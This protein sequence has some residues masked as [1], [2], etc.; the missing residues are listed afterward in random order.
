MLRKVIGALKTVRGFFIDESKDVEEIDIKKWLDNNLEYG[1]Y[2]LTDTKVT[3]TA[4][5][6]QSNGVHIYSAGS[7][8]TEVGGDFI[9]DAEPSILLMIDTGKGLFSNA[10]SQEELID[11]IGAGDLSMN[12]AVIVFY[13]DSSVKV[14]ALRSVNN[15]EAIRWLKYQGTG[16]V[17][18]KILKSGIRTEN[19]HKEFKEEYTENLVQLPDKGAKMYI[20]LNDKTLDKI[21]DIKRAIRE[22]RERE[23]TDDELLKSFKIKI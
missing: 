4:N 6:L 2:L 18:Q 8:I 17:T 9:L 23:F 19:N 13:T 3:R 11:V 12:K 21:E 14:Q 10:K 22:T 16:D 7:S 20:G 5:F 1:V 15:A